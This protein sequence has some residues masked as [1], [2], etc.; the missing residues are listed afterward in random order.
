MSVVPAHHGYGT[1]SHLLLSMTLFL[2]N[3]HGYDHDHD[4]DGDDDHGRD[5]GCLPL[6]TLC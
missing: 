4:H 2:L 1:P 3:P 5:D 6:T